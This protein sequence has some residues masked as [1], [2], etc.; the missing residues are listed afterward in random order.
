MSGTPDGEF[1][2]SKCLIYF[3]VSLTAKLSEVINKNF[4]VYKNFLSYLYQAAENF[5]CRKIFRKQIFCHTISKVIDMN[6][7]QI[8]Y[9]SLSQEE[10]LLIEDEFIR[11]CELNKDIPC[12]EKML[13]EIKKDNRNARKYLRDAVIFKDDKSNIHIYL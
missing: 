11:S 4:F 8:R 3:K 12:I 6:T 10:K 2:L 13:N 5:S 1:R 7:T 9:S